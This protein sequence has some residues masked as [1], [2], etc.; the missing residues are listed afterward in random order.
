MYY[1]EKINQIKKVKGIKNEIWKDI[2]GY[3]SLYQISNLG[4][5]KSLFGWNGHEYVK[6]EKILKLN[7]TADGYLKV[8]LFD[9]TKRKQ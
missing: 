8:S 1:N 3:E 9:N 5:V 6:R 4:R 2:Y 7:E